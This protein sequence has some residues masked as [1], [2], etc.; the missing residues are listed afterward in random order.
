MALTTPLSFD[1]AFSA[2][3]GCNLT[4][5]LTAIVLVGAFGPADSLF[6]KLLSPLFFLFGSTTAGAVYSFGYTLLVGAIMN[7]ICGVTASRLM[8]KSLSRYK[9]FRKPYLYGGKR[10]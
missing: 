1:R 2:L 3:L 10:A 4:L 9:V 8:L 6:A 7:F 5:M